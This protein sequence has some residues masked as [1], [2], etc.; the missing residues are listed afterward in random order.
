MKAKYN[1]WENRELCAL[2]SGLWGDFPENRAF[3]NRE[4][5]SVIRYTPPPVPPSKILKTKER[6]CKIL[7]SKELF[8]KSRAEET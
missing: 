6:V 8:V 3:L 1:R 2:W 7:R 5:L 4:D